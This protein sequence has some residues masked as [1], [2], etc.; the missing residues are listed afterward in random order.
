MAQKMAQKRLL[1]IN[2]TYNPRDFFFYI[3]E[4]ERFVEIGDIKQ[5]V[6]KGTLIENPKGIPHLLRNTNEHVFRFLVAKLI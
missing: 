5:R 4:G 6:E 2:K 3:L 1:P